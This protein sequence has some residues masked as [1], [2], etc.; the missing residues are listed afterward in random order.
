MVV[1]IED[2]KDSTCKVSNLTNIANWPI[3]MLIHKNQLLS[4]IET[5]T[6][7]RNRSN[8]LSHLFPDYI[9]FYIVTKIVE[10]KR[11]IKCILE[12]P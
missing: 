4:F 11:K 10:I 2:L 6:Q 12:V 3:K 8:G 5:I 7:L 1:Y 9:I